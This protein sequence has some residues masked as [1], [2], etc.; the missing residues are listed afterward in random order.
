MAVPTLDQH[1]PAARR[2]GCAH[3]GGTH[4]TTAGGSEAAREGAGGEVLDGLTRRW[5]WERGG[6]HLAPE[7]RQAART[8]GGLVMTRLG[9][10]PAV[11]DRITVAGRTLVVEAMDGC[12]VAAVRVLPA[13]AQSS[14][15]L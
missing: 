9:R 11:G 7:E 5:E 10:V 2:A 1:T 12:R 8:L 13:P 3:G 4:P 15:G 14:C 6:A